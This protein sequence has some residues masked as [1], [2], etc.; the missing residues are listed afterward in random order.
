MAPMLR[1]ARVKFTK[2]IVDKVTVQRV[3]PQ[4][5]VVSGVVYSRPIVLSVDAVVSD[6][7]AG[8][9]AQLTTGHFDALLEA[10]PELVLVG[11]GATSVFPPRDLMFAFA[12][13][14]IGLETMDTA[15]AART[16]NVL[17]TEGRRVAAVLYPP[18]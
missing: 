13:H 2:E 15:A 5:I 7:D 9:V 4:G 10:S 3:T 8:P 16:W 17:A 12:R 1:D 6:W 11:T 18:T 14:G